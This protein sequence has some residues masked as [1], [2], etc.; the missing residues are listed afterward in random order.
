MAVVATLKLAY[1]LLPVAVSAVLAAMVAM[2]ALVAMVAMEQ[3]VAV[4]KLALTVLLVPMT[5]IEHMLSHIHLQHMLT[6]VLKVL[7]SC[8]LLTL[9]L[10]PA[11]QQYL[12]VALAVLAMGY[13]EGA[14]DGHS[15]TAIMSPMKTPVV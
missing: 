5:Q 2:V 6:V 15:F 13:P 10:L 8:S 11:S 1:M 12:Q 3:L 14:P 9:S 7:T 4:E